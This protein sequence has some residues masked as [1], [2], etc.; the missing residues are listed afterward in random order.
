MTI[1]TYQPGDDV[2][3]VSIY[4]EASADLPKFNGDLVIDTLPSGVRVDL[5]SGLPVIA[6]AYD[7]GGLQLLHE[8]AG[9]QND[10]FLEVFG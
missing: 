6:A 8:Q 10:L 1:R 3:Q 4:N 9:P 5:P 2:A 7:R